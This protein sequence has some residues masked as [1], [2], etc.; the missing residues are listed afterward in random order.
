MA[1]WPLYTEWSQYTGQLYRKYKANENFG[2]LSDDRNI[3]G[4]LYRKYKATEN[5]G[6]LSGDRNIQGDRYIQGRYK[7]V[8]LYH[9]LGLDGSGVGREVLCKLSTSRGLCLELIYK[10]DAAERFTTRITLLS[11]PS[12]GLLGL[13]IVSLILL[14]MIQVRKSLKVLNMFTIRPRWVRIGRHSYT[15]SL[16]YC[17]HPLFRPILVYIVL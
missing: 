2:K 14:S 9:V 3:Q 15:C 10:L 5:F 16:S 7:Q 11:L 8:W 1:R 13:G 12:P 6:K 17:A 4:D